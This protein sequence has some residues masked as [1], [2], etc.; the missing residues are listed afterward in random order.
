[1]IPAR[2]FYLHSDRRLMLRKASISETCL[3]DIAVYLFYGSFLMTF[4]DIRAEHESAPF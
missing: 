4:C 1:M 2:K 3:L